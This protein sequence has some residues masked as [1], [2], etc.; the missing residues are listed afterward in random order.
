[1]EILEILKNYLMGFPKWGDV[2]LQIDTTDPTPGSCGL[3]PLGSEELSRR[4]D[5]MGNVKCR[6][7][8]TFL[9]RRVANRGEQA[10]AWLMELARWMGQQPPP[11]VG[12]NPGI[13]GEKGRL[14]NPGQTGAATY[15]MGIIL[16]YDKEM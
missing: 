2:R 14:V 7:R 16:E 11:T 5:V 1:M 8:H 9:L 10:A 3:F 6:L 12:E 13:R 4:E 15:E